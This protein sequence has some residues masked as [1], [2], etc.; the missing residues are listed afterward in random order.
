[1]DVVEWTAQFA[2]L[3][4]LATLITCMQW[5]ALD[6]NESRHPAQALAIESWPYE[7]LG[8]PQAENL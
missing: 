6:F 7:E 2:R 5:P 8:Q 3:D 1:M 4:K